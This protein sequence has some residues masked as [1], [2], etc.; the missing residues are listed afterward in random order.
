MLQHYMILALIGLVGCVSNYETISTEVLGS[1]PPKDQLKLSYKMTVPLIES[2]E[3]FSTQGPREFYEWA[4]AAGYP[5]AQEVMGLIYLYQDPIN[6]EKGL[7]FL[8][9]A[10]AAERVTA[11][12]ELAKLYFEG[13]LIEKNIDKALSYL[14]MGIE[15]H[16]LI[17]LKL[18]AKIEIGRNN[19]SKG[20]LYLEQ[21]A[22]I[23][24]PEAKRQLA[25]T[26]LQ[27][28]K[29]S[30]LKVQDLNQQAYDEGLYEELDDIKDFWPDR[31]QEGVQ[32][33]RG[34]MIL[35]KDE[36]LLSFKKSPEMKLTKDFVYEFEKAASKGSPYAAYQ[37]VLLRL[38]SPTAVDAKKN[39]DDILKLLNLAADKLVPAQV[40]KARLIMQEYWAEY[41]FND[42][43]LLLK[44]AANQGHPYALL[45]M[46]LIEKN[47]GHYQKAV[48]LYY[49]AKKNA[50]V[51][52]SQYLAAKDMIQGYFPFKDERNAYDWISE[53]AQVNYNPALLELAELK[54][55]GS[56]E[57][58][59]A[60]EI[61]MLRYKAAWQGSTK[62]QYLIANMYLKGE[63]VQSNEAKAFRW[64]NLAARR[65]YRPAQLQLGLMFENGCGTIPNLVKAYAWQKI[66]SEKLYES[67][68]EH[69]ISIIDQLS[70]PELAEALRYE[71]IFKKNY[72]IPGYYLG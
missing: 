69:L 9:K 33:P 46:S 29:G 50:D 62:A 38:H 42:A 6:I 39:K 47:N 19:N 11:G 44:E 13:E 28:R 2:T 21:A 71:K 10:F 30:W 23:G 17:S 41:T 70:Q 57:S 51:S 49:E 24:D 5:Q 59:S 31:Y 26:L 34:D 35:S 22:E 68:Q 65:G 4:S 48:E 14:E 53:L 61:F 56:I 20:M 60:I 37:E 55:K 18:A 8:E 7:F 32:M 16:D 66:G 64:F 45:A 63:G 72:L 36:S 67:N 43:V 3:K 58:Y 54:E 15:Q 52:Y 40:L 1:E 12:V 27:E 25:Q